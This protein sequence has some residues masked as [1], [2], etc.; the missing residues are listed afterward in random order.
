M[1]R[2]TIPLT[3]AAVLLA[4]TPARPADDSDKGTGLYEGFTRLFNGKDLTGWQVFGGKEEA[5]GA[6]DG[7]LF[8]KGGGGGWLLTDKEYSDFEIYVDFKMPADGGGNSG[9]AL[10]PRWRA[11][12]LTRAWRSSCS[13]TFGTSTRRTSRVSSQ[14]S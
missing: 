8:T 4:L 3:L 14:C 13:T 5:W 1:F 11:T 9:V 2:R 12:Y 7:T 6:E 10:R